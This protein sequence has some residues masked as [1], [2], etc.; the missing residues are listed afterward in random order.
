VLPVS[1]V[2]L[3]SILHIFFRNL[4]HCLFFILLIS[5]VFN[6]QT[7][8]VIGWLLMF[9]LVVYYKQSDSSELF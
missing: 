6:N 1:A 7:K 2:V 4:L 9:C 5:N 3:N 8:T